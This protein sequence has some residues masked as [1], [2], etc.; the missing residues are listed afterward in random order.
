MPGK[1]ISSIAAPSCA[2][3]DGHGRNGASLVSL[4][5]IFLGEA[6]DNAADSNRD[7]KDKHDHANQ[8]EMFWTR[9]A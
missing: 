5:M 2:D 8:L 9:Y 4:E 1:T 7:E 3:N 6:G